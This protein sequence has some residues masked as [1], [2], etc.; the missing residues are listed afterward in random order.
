[1]TI[2]KPPFLL[3]FASAFL[4]APPDFSDE[5]FE[6][7]REEKLE[8]FGE[9]R[10]HEVLALLATLRH[11]YGIYLLDVNPGNIKFSGEEDYLHN[12]RVIIATPL[13]DYLER[14]FFFVPRHL[15]AV[16]RLSTASFA[17]APLKSLRSF[18]AGETFLTLLLSFITI[19]YIC[20]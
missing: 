4:D 19:V 15:P 20:I 17:V 18:A 16:G 2:V 6:E 13:K 9:E 10:W 5:I 12:F 8:L 11:R 3:D 1:M 7:W 14:S